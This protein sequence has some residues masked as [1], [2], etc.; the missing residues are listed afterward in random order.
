[1]TQQSGGALATPASAAAA[2]SGWRAIAP[3]LLSALA[4]LAGAW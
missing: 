2:P 4:L 3:G 1:V